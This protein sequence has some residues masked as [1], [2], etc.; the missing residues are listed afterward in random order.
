MGASRI[1][2]LV[3]NVLFDLKYGRFLGGKKHT[4]YSLMGANV[5]ANS[6]YKAMTIFFKGNIKLDDV[7][8]DVGCGKGRVINFW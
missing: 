2:R 7:L 8:V 3:Y 4:P 6:D 1:Y 5:T